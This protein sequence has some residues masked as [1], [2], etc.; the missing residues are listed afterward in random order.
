MERR[1]LLLKTTTKNS[2]NKNDSKIKEKLNE[3]FSEF[4]QECNI[5]RLILIS[6]ISKNCYLFSLYSSTF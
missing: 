2:K 3:F 6:F 1:I 5:G 4:V